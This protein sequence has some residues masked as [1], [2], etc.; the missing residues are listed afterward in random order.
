MTFWRPRSSSTG[1]IVI[2]GIRQISRPPPQMMPI[3]WMPLKLVN[4]IARNAPAVVKPP[5]K[6]PCPV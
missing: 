3:S 4:P 1:S 2:I 5:V 6:M